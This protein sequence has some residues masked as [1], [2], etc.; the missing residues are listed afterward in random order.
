MYQYTTL[1]H[2]LNLLHSFHL[3][4]A[5]YTVHHTGTVNC[6]EKEMQCMEKG[7]VKHSI[8]L[9]IPAQAHSTWRYEWGSYRSLWLNTNVDVNS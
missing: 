3:M 8:F 1:L 7:M 6:E 5:K 9:H 2:L 4:K